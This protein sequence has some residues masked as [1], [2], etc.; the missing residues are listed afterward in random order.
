MGFNNK[1]PKHLIKFIDDGSVKLIER[2]MEKLNEY[3]M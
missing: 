3:H 2:Y 1:K